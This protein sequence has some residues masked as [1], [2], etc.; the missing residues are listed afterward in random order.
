MFKKLLGLLLA[1]LMLLG[2]VGVAYATGAE[3]AQPDP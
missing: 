3:T 1:C 2:A